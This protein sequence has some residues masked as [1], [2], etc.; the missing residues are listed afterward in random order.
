MSEL[1]P[2]VTP[3]H[4]RLVVA[5]GPEQLHS[6]VGFRHQLAARLHL[7]SNGNNIE[8]DNLVSQFQAKRSRNLVG[9]GTVEAGARVRR[10]RGKAPKPLAQGALQIVTD[11][12]ITPVASDFRSA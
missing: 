8:S 5:P 7:M 2:R 6:R 1:S 3:Q 10:I 11:L 9:I 12:T 4:A